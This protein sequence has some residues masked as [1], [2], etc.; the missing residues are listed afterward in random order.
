MDRVEF[1]LKTDQIRTYI[2]EGEFEKAAELADSINWRKVKQVSSLCLAGEAYEK[3]QRYED[4]KELLLMAYDRTPIGRNIVYKLAIVAVKAGNFQEAEEFYEE[5]LHIAANDNI[6]YLLKYQIA[7]GKGEPLTDLIQILEE[8]KEL[9]SSERWSYELAS[10]YHK[11]GM[12]D[13]C[14]ALCDELVLWYGEGKYVEKALELKM[15]Y[16]PLSVEQEKRYTQIRQNREGVMEVESGEE[17]ASGEIATENIVIPQVEYKQVSFDT[18]NLQQELQANMKQIME[19]TERGEVVDHMEQIKKLVNQIPYLSE[20]AELN[21]EEEEK[22]GHIE[23]DEEIDGSLK[24][25]FKNLLAEDYDGQISMNVPHSALAE[26]QINGQMSIEDVLGEWEKTKRAAQTALEVANQRKLESAKARAL[27]E[28]EGIMDRLQDVI[29]QLNAMIDA[30]L[31]EEEAVQEELFP[32]MQQDEELD[33]ELNEEYQE[34]F[35]EDSPEELCEDIPQT[36][37]LLKE[38]VQEVLKTE[39]PVENDSLQNKEV[40]HEFLNDV[41][42]ELETIAETEPDLVKSEEQLDELLN[43]ATKKMDFVQECGYDGN[44]QVDEEAIPS[45]NYARFLTPEQKDV[46]SY[47]VTVPGMEKQI[48]QAMEEVNRKEDKTS[49]SGNIVIVGE[50]GSGKTQLATNLVKVLQKK[51]IHVNGKVGK[52]SAAVL[53]KKDIVDLISR[54]NGGYLII[55]KAGELSM[56][57]ATKLSFAMEQETNR[58]V[59]ILE[60]TKAG[61]RELSQMNPEF[62]KKFSTK[63]TIPLFTN[64]ELVNFAKSYAI[65]RQYEIDEMAILALYKRIS[66]IQKVE[67]ATTLTEVKEIVDEA[68]SRAKKGGLKRKFAKGF[69]RKSEEEDKELLL[70]IDFE[71]E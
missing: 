11:A 38:I 26:P 33:E 34:N 64:D 50:R 59:V 22:Y 20:T 21:L 57:T 14:V 45:K 24:I 54:M 6:R 56:E 30:Q 41:A 23:T 31:L 61:V 36:Q 53:N 7:R 12:V 15:L 70:E 58:M 1:K 35:T 25:N 71:R 5:F 69:S 62:Y 49:V 60:D 55:E 65:E 67:R 39:L 29:P 44:E 63:I 10:L 28:A 32:E 17:F 66:N 47:F 51:A 42:P 19:A 46:F 2:E 43:Q 48:C 27:Q 8:Y 4:S 18:V 68:I 16:Q 13:A 40:I 9:E 37:D 3:A 52:I